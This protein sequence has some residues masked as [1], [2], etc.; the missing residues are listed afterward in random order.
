MKSSLKILLVALLFLSAC[1]A[2]KAA[3]LVNDSQEKIE[4]VESAKAPAS[5][6]VMGL[7]NINKQDLLF[8]INKMAIK[9]K[10]LLVQVQYGGGCVKPH[11]FELITN[12]IINKEGGMDFYLL[13]KTHNDMC[14]ALLI[15]DLTF[16]LEKLYNLQSNVL[17]NIRINKMPKIDLK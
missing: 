11:E 13:H 10:I 14:K 9:D 12:G 2:R 4:I 6:E 3:S 7:D 16:N 5:F 1:K 15:E 8:H 17:K